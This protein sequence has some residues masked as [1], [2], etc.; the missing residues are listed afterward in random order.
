[1]PKKTKNQSINLNISKIQQF[2][3]SV[4]N[5]LDSRFRNNILYFHLKH[6]KILTY[7][8]IKQ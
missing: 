2:L 8:K 7:E 4:H 1:M 3:K 6:F 5:S